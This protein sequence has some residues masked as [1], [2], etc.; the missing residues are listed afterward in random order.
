MCVCV[1]CREQLFCHQGAKC[2]TWNPGPLAE[3]FG[4]FK[5]L[6]LLVEPPN[7][8]ETHSSWGR[9]GNH[10]WVEE[11][12]R[13]GAGEEKDQWGEGGSGRI[14]PRRRDGKLVGAG[15]QASRKYFPASNWGRDAARGRP[16][17]HW[18]F[19]QSQH[20]LELSH[21]LSSAAAKRAS[22]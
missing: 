8:R 18:F 3:S 9:G 7:K 15:E 5:V 14:R 1:F 16:R 2:Y 17:P 6:F 4:C 20:L 22:P 12:R 10:R 11:S 21:F 19:G 13:R